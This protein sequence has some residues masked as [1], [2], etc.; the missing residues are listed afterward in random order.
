MR[1]PLLKSKDEGNTLP[2]TAGFDDR[3]ASRGRWVIA[4]RQVESGWDLDSILGE[5]DR[6]FAA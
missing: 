4:F 1:N 3:N 2:E 5:F 6:Y